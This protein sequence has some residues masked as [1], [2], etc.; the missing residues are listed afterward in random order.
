MRPAVDGPTFD[1]HAYKLSERMQA[2][3]YENVQCIEAAAAVDE[4]TGTAAIFLLNR[5]WEDPIDI[6]LDIHG[7]KGYALSKHIQLCSE[8]LDA[9]NT[10]EKPDLIAPRIDE[11]T[12][13][14]GETIALCA[15]KLSFNVILLM[16]TE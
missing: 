7:F 8:D 4:G 3:G 5:S 16:R 13:Q 1:A 15:E 2:P 14:S 6:E 11:R 9:F 10:F 12:T